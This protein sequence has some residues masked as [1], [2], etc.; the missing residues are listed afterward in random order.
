MVQQVKNLTSKDAAL[1]PGLNQWFKDLAWL[2]AA[3]QIEDAAQIWRG[4]GC[5]CG[6]GQQLQLRFSPQPG[7]FRM[8][9]VQAWRGG[10]ERK[11]VWG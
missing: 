4:C 3:A 6:I 9:E 11:G 2:Q 7:K 1:I 8:L 10:R 5:G